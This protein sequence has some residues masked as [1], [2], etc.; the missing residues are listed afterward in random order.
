MVA[1]YSRDLREKVV[2]L[3][4]TCQYTIDEIASFFFSP[5][6]VKKY[7]SLHKNEQSLEPKKPTGRKKTIT[8]HEESLLLNYVDNYPDATLEEYNSMLF[9]DTGL[10]VT[11]QSIHY[12]LKKLNITYK[13]KSIRQ[14]AGT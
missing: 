13:K 6:S 11:V 10:K 3:K 5:T 4:L 8:K 9:K 2:S 7:V 14:G 1:A 12:A